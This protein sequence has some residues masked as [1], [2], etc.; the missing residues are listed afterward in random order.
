[1]Q[2]VAEKQKKILVL[3][4]TLF[5]LWAVICLIWT[6]HTILQEYL[7]E[8]AQNMAAYKESCLESKGTLRHNSLLFGVDL[9][10]QEP[11]GNETVFIN[12]SQLSFYYFTY[13]FFDRVSFNLLGL[14]DIYAEACVSECDRPGKS[15]L[16]N[17][18]GVYILADENGER[19]IKA[20]NKVQIEMVQ[21]AKC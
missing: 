14:R 8:R 9:Y 21:N 13:T 1:M 5:G 6:Y 4:Q 12:T 10:C 15:F 7:V 20:Y 3:A 17:N 19:W 16:N 2:I 11:N 18:A